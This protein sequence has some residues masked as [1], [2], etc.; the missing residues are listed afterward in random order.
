[1]FKVQLLHNLF[2]EHG[3]SGLRN[4]LSARK[5]L[6]KYFSLC[7]HIHRYILYVK[8][9]I[10]MVYNRDDHANTPNLQRIWSS[11]R[12]KPYST[13]YWAK[14]YMVEEEMS[15]NFSTNVNANQLWWH[16]TRQQK[17]PRK[18]TREE[19]RIFRFS[20]KT[21]LTIPGDIKMMQEAPRCSQISDNVSW[22]L[23]PTSPK[24]NCSAKETAVPIPNKTASVRHSLT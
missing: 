4:N 2:P 10:M 6:I 8:T 20:L 12:Q 14:S 5:Y 16:H 18:K 17:T 24:C 19:H 7:I 15:I 3:N 1:M 11:G 23:I 22:F 9:I 13:L 21:D